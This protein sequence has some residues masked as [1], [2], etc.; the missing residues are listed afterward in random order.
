MNTYDLVTELTER[1]AHD[2]HDFPNESELAYL[3]QACTCVDAFA[4]SFNA[5]SIKASYNNKLNCI[6]VSMT[7]PSIRVTPDNH[8]AFHDL[9]WQTG[10]FR[11]IPINDKEMRIELD[12]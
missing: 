11:L 2:R 8:R 12:L 3:S 4:S 10:S 9:T 7:C 5:D 1:I 6:T